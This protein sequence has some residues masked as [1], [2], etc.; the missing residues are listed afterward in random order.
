MMVI[1]IPVPPTSKPMPRV[2]STKNGSVFCVR[3]ASTILAR[4]ISASWSILT[5]ITRT[6]RPSKRRCNAPKVGI[7][8][9]QATHHV[10]HKLTTNTSP[11][12]SASVRMRPS[13]STSARVGSGGGSSSTISRCISPRANRARPAVCSGFDAAAKST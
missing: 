6:P 10:A 9:T 1:G 5:G 7:S 13:A 8:S 11:S 2:M 4:A 3:C 12:N